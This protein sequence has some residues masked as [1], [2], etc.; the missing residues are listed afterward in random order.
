MRIIVRFHELR[1]VV[2][3][4]A[5]NNHGGIPRDSY[6]YYWVFRRAL[7]LLVLLCVCIFEAVSKTQSTVSDISTEHK[8]SINSTVRTLARRQCLIAWDKP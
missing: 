6:M 7:K 1:V 8:T 4:D 2:C 5:Q 3:I